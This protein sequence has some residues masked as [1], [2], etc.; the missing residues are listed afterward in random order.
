MDQFGGP[1]MRIHPGKRTFARRNGKKMTTDY[2]IVGSGLAGIALAEELRARG[3]DF[4]VFE[5]GSQTSSLVAG[6]M[7]NPV[8]LKRFNP[9]WKGAGQLDEALPF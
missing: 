6:G 3:L 9:V 7:Y 1:W 2:I 5:D 8:V 4:V